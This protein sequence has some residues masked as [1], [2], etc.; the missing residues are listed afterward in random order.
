MG[1]PEKFRLLV[2]MVRRSN[3]GVMGEVSLMFWGII[4][5][6]GPRGEEGVSCG[7]TLHRNE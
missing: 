3:A 4:D 2:S 6:L 1:W 7:R 5:I